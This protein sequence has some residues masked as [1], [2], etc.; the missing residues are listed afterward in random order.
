MVMNR[1]VTGAITVSAVLLCAGP[2]AAQ[3]DTFKGRLSP[4]PVESSTIA[5]ISGSGSV[6]AT[7]NGRS[8]SIRGTFEGMQSPATLAQ[9]HLGPKGVRGPVMFDLT[10]TKATSGTISGTV[11]LSPE[12]V[13]AVKHG[14]FY[15]QIH[16]EKSQDGNLW[17]WLIP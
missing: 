9:V 13:E 2:A 15:I 3:G 17:G 8:L 5:G 12:Q 10:A 4:V 7:L 11:T 6:T 16:S 14:R 1:V